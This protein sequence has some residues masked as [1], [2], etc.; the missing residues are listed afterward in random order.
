MPP[1]FFGRLSLPA[2]PL[3]IS[4]W[5]GTCLFVHQER[6]ST[7]E[8]PRFRG[9]EGTG[10]SQARDLPANFGPKSNLVWKTVVPMG[11]SSPVVAGN[12]IWLAGYEGNNRLVWCLDLNTGR[13]LWEQAVVARGDERKSVPNDAASSTP[14]TDGVNVCALF[15]RLRIGVLRRKRGGALAG[16]GWVRSRS[17]MEWPVHRFSLGNQ[18]IV[19]ADEVQDSYLA[20]FDWE[21]GKLKWRTAR[22]NFVGGYS[23]PVLWH[24]QVVVAGPV[25]LVAYAQTTGRDGIVV[26]AENGG[27]AGG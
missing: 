8:W 13:R 3:G 26:G 6:G 27:D 10:V 4:L 17:R 5:I 23:T 9:F 12:R 11:C 16:S 25:E 24:D 22:P 15:S 19:L 1:S 2:R 7:D 20:A 18:V 21:S 14:V